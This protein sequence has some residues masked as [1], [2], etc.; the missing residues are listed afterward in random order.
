MG[1]YFSVHA[2]PCIIAAIVSSALA[3]YIYAKKLYAKKPSGRFDKLFALLMFSFAVL[4]LGQSGICISTDHA[5]AVFWARIRLLGMVFFAPLFLHTVLAFADK[6][7]PLLGRVRYLY[8]PSAFFSLALAPGL[9]T[10]AVRPWG[11]HD[12]EAA[13]ALLWGS[14][15]IILAYVSYAAHVLVRGYTMGID[16]ARRRTKPL[17]LGALALLIGVVVWIAGMVGDSLG[18]AT[19]Y[20]HS[21][22]G[23]AGIA[24]S[25]LY[26]YA[27]T[28]YKVLDVAPVVELKAEAAEPALQPG[29]AVLTD[30]MDKS[31]QDLLGLV[32]QGYH[33]LIATKHQPEKVRMETALERT[34]ILRLDVEGKGDAIDARKLENLF[35]TLQE[36]VG[37]GGKGAILV[38]DLNYLLSVNSLK[39]LRAFLANIVELLASKRGVLILEVDEQ[40]MNPDVLAELRHFLNYQHLMPVFSCLSNPIRKDIVLYLEA[41]KASFTE[42]YRASGLMFPSKLSFHLNFLRDCGLIEQDEERK[43]SLTWRGRAA[44]EMLRGMEDELLKKFEVK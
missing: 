37:K 19:Q 17:L 29:M 41:G 15:L 3:L 33:G 40:K 8:L 23:S 21:F 5:T 12:F 38:E 24:M 13:G 14:I 25:I 18:P 2:L 20:I 28:R 27:V 9:S 35:L 26:S 16:L 7:N 10:L 4:A 34:P 36:F 42:I 1:Y 39:D 6:D 43:Y 11:G 44:L 22:L 30:G 31:R 32:S